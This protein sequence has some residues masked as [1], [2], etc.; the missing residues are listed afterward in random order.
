MLPFECPACGEEVDVRPSGPRTLA[1]RN[2]EA[3]EVPSVDLPICSQCGEEWLDKEATERLHEALEA[4]YASALHDRAEWAL[5]RLQ[6]AIQQRDLERLLGLSGG[7]LSKLKA[8]KKTSGPLTAVLLLLATDTR[9][10]DELRALLRHGR[11]QEMG[12][13]APV[14]KTVAKVVPIRAP[15]V[16]AELSVSTIP[17]VATKMSP[18][19]QH[20][21]G[22]EAEVAA[23]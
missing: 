12:L 20:T 21:F 3:L 16:T 7:Y 8:G 6:C 14:R 22:L 17:S 15:V 10:I 18:L 13:Q 2:I 11:S 9:R 5:G 4:A 19:E 23:A 1:Y